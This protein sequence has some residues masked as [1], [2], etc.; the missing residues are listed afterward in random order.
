MA[1]YSYEPLPPIA[2]QGQTPPFTRLM[3][4]NPGSGEQPLECTLSIIDPTNSP[5]RYEALSYVWGTERAENPIRCHGGTISITANLERALRDLRL[6]YLIRPLWVDAIC[7]N[8]QDVDER[9]RQ[10]AY[11]RL[12]YQHAGRVVVYLGPS[13][14]GRKR[15]FARAREL[16]DFRAMLLESLPESAHQA[17]FPSQTSTRID[18][19]MLDALNADPQPKDDL[20][21]LFKSTYFERVWCIQEVAASRE[22]IAK[23]GDAEIN[24]YDLLSVA[25]LMEPLEIESGQVRPRALKLWL[26]VHHQR[27]REYRP[28]RLQV[29]GSIGGILLVLMNIRN[30][31]CTDPRDRLFGILGITDEGLE[32][33]LANMD[34]LITGPTLRA[35][36]TTMQKTFAWL[37]KKVSTL[38]PN[39]EISRRNPAI[40]PNYTKSAMEV[41][42]DFTRFMVRKSPRVLD[43][44]SHVQHTSDPTPGSHPSW[45]PK[46]DEPQSCS[47]IPPRLFIPGIPLTGH[48][49][50]FAVLHDC[51]LRGMPLEPNVLQLDGFRLDVVEAVSDSIGTD[52]EELREPLPLDQIWSQLFA[53]P[54]FPRPRLK[55]LGGHELLDTAFYVALCAGG[56]GLLQTMPH[57]VESLDNDRLKGV[58]V[59]AENA[60]HQALHYLTL[61]YGC[62]ASTYQDLMPRPGSSVVNVEPT[63]VYYHMTITNAVLN[64]RVYRTRSGYLGIGPKFMKPG[65]QLVVLYGGHTPF[66]LRQIGRDWIFVGDAYVHYWDLMTGQLVDRVRR[67]RTN[68]PVET[69][70]LI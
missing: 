55:Y 13:D 12:V 34:V 41:Y 25:S 32:P 52:L 29:Q 47:L 3:C 1:S 69:F 43:V 39:T 6:P 53:F 22:C 21:V 9:A 68:I 27:N 62:T 8:Q 33:V 4:L 59:L 45:V 57:I 24:F 50:Y 5:V 14:A 30:F 2:E 10:V 16:C 51:P 65:D 35:F 58:E 56:S 15:A 64:K 63:P 28:D 70:R 31:K 49:R 20:T 44:L 18:E 7:I 19:M 40:T 36:H 37:G 66:I 11:M 38:G 26:M 42:R 61:L 17:T 67:G 46:F 23:S 54:L 60:K 48:Y